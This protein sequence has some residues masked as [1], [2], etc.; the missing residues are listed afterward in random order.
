MISR[1]LKAVFIGCGGLLILPLSGC[2]TSGVNQPGVQLQRAVATK[3]AQTYIVQQAAVRT[4][5]TD[6]LQQAQRQ[7][8]FQPDRQS[9]ARAATSSP[10]AKAQAADAGQQAQQKAQAAEILRQ[11][12]ASR[13]QY[14]AR[15]QARQQAA[16]QAAT[17]QAQAAAQQAQ[18]K[19]Q[20]AATA[21][22]QA[23]QAQAQ[24]VASNQ[25]R[26]QRARQAQQHTT[27]KVMPQQQTK[28]DDAAAKRQF[29]LAR[30]ERQQAEKR[31][32]AKKAEQKV[33][34]V[35]HNAKQQ[36]GSKYVWGGASPETGFDCSGLVQ[37]S[38]KQGANVK[39]PRT[40]AEQY[41]AAVKVPGQQASRGDLVFFKTRGSSV[42]HVGIYL[43]DNKF[44][45]APRT[46]Q[47]IQT[48]QIAGY[49]KQ[50]LVGFGRIPGACKVPV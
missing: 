33:E 8:V 29:Y 39:V 47:K 48:S 26:Q 6:R 23:R 14:H 2:V 10:L 3:P 42:S 15:Y 9:I 7:P 36:I 50:R 24:T 34:R 17:R 46:G 45:H 18:Q 11:Q 28:A 19:A 12:N 37:H 35:I 16:N 44:V 21:A 22:Q 25:A 43:G 5:G 20:A 31:L 30:W 49:W 13:A 27:R 4:P 38:I 32:E 40:A 41:R 1:S